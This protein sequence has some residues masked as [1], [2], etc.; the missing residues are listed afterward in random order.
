M[1]D[2]IP[3]TEENPLI[4]RPTM[5]EVYIVLLK[6]K[7]SYQT[8]CGEV[9]EVNEI[10]NIL[11]LTDKSKKHS[12]ILKDGI[13]VL[14]SKDQ[15]YHIVDIQRV[16]L[17]DLS[18]LKKDETQIEKLLTSDIIQG[19]EI[20][21]D[22]IKEKDMIYT[23]VELK[24]SLIASFIEIYDAYDKIS[25]IK[26]INSIVDYFFDLFKQTKQSNTYQIYKDDILPLWLIPLVDNP[27]KLYQTEDQLEDIKVISEIRESR[28][29]NYYQK[30]R[31][32]LDKFIPVN[33]SLSDTGY[34]TNLAVHRYLKNCLQEETC[35]S[36]P[37]RNYRYDKRSNKSSLI[38]N[39]S[40]IHKP[41]TLNISG[42]LYIPDS[43]LIQSLRPLH[44]TQ[45]YLREKIIIQKLIQKHYLNIHQLKYQ[46]ILTKTI[47]DQSVLTNESIDLLTSYIFTKKLTKEEFYDIIH[48]LSPNPVKVL[49]MLEDS[50]K[51]SL[52][53]LEDIKRIFIKFNIDI[54]SLSKEDN[55]AILDIIS[56]NYK[57]Y[58]KNT[59]TLP[60]TIV[61]LVKKDIP[62][63]EKIDKSLSLILKMLS[64][65]KKNEYLQSFIKLFTR[66]PTSSED[67][68]SLYNIYTNESILCK[69]YLFSSCYHVN[70]DAH[71]SMLSIYGTPPVDGSIYCK[72]CGEFLC[73]EDFSSF[74]GFDDET[75]IQLREV[76]KQEMNI[77]DD[78][79]EDQILLV[80]TIASSLGVTIN[81]PDIHLILSIYLPM[82]QDII[83]NTRYST[84]NI[85]ESDEHPLIKDIRQKYSKEKN[86]K[87][88]IKND[89]RKFQSYLK[90]TNKV[91]ALFSLTILVI[92][93]SIP[94]YSHK[95]GS[96]FHFT[97][98]IAVNNLS[99]N[100]S[101][102]D[103]CIVKLTKLCKYND[104]SIWIHCTQL[105]KE[106]KLYEVHSVKQQMLCLLDLFI[107]SQFNSIQKRIIEYGVFLKNS[108]TIYIKDEWV[109]FKPLRNNQQIKHS[110]QVLLTKDPEYKSYYILD[111]NNY[112]VENV[113]LLT[114]LSDQTPIYK[115]IKIPV[116]EIM[117]NKSFLLLF[118]LAV[119]NYG[120]MNKVVSS[121]YLHI[122]RFI[123]TIKDK[124]EIVRIFSEHNFPL[125]HPKKTSYKA[126]RTKIIPDI[127]NYYQK[128]DQTLEPC[129]HTNQCNQ[130]I[131]IHMNNFDYMLLKGKPKRYYSYYPPNIYPEKSFDELSDEFKQKLFHRYCLDPNDQVIKKLLNDSYLGKFILPLQSDTEVDIPDSI[132]NYEKK[133]T[134]NEHNFKLILKTIQ[135][136]LLPLY[137]FIKPQPK[138]IDDYH[139]TIEKGNIDTE[140]NI[141]QL[142]VDNMNYDLDKPL[143]IDQLMSYSEIFNTGKSINRILTSEFKRD[144]DNNI[145]QIS[146][147]PLITDLSSFI[148]HCQSK[149]HKKRFESIFI[150]TSQSMNITQEERNQLE[151]DDFRY[152]NLREKDIFKLLDMFS[153][154]PNM[155]GSI[156]KKY[157]YHMKYILSMLKNPKYNYSD[158]IPNVWK[159]S[160]TSRSAYGQ[161]IQSNKMFLH[162]DL[163]TL[164]PQY[165]GY[166]NYTQTYIFASLY[167][168]ISPYMNHLELLELSTTR[169]I[170]ETILQFIHRYI[171]MCLF[172]KLY[173]F[174]NQVKEENQEVISLLVSHIGKDEDFSSVE[175]VDV[176]ENFIMD[177]LTDILQTHYDSKWIVRNMNKDDLIKLLSKQKEKEK[178][179][180]IHKLDTMSDEKRSVTMELQKTGQRNWFKTSG[181]ENVKRVIDEYSNSP[182]NERYAL[183]NGILQEDT[184]IDDVNGVYSGELQGESTYSM[185]QPETLSSETISENIGY[186]N[187]NDIDEDGQMGDELHEFYDE[188]LLDNDFVE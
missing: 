63:Q 51:Q 123:D 88:L 162:K 35:V 101:V 34:T 79:K 46:P 160:D 136:K 48:K 57:T 95:T 56:D 64:I 112:P 134:M 183:F 130:F 12:F 118:K 69:H 142:F 67:K 179:S 74:D 139:V 164:N 77:L 13:L 14:K 3:I 43:Q 5:K 76:M 115:H 184:I 10:D 146:N 99:I 80:K 126:L 82:N 9:S 154:D 89:V 153:S 52:Y 129:Y 19:L 17:F 110:D 150:N 55:S 133:M 100:K 68:H 135:S 15:D 152:R 132:H 172:H 163:F 104:D 23:D 144:F 39:Q 25:K 93:T 117:I 131:H 108:Q 6:E 103:F 149:N 58:I 128:T 11:I 169:L 22:E 44:S 141:I 47:D 124:E 33:P 161:Y 102:I 173:E 140:S 32:I 20:S 127:L 158:Y 28:N 66:E 54:S 157:I 107:S 174:Y 85:A 167:E 147:L 96:M 182:D 26:E 65:F 143:F 36:W 109:L 18:I 122:D 72:H 84:Q 113:S 105:L 187:M 61:R 42:L 83:A 106:D 53:N 21:L 98:S 8:I 159:L 168:F 75:P 91:I 62:I 4:I 50:M 177:M 78:F 125:D 151:Q 30:I 116:S 170:D 180:L 120:E 49:D 178:Q 94:A 60:K 27:S 114:P 181:E 92:Q 155:T 185:L 137:E 7:D 41:D 121:L 186:M 31:S 171:I 73:H 90:D 81:E 38:M 119:T 2:E 156:V 166:H 97:D 71:K 86:K 111:Y 175:V 45:L 1:G 145:S 40:I 165:K 16:V 24:E 59:P 148:F 29:T 87:E 70:K 176:L 138:I 188:D 37:D